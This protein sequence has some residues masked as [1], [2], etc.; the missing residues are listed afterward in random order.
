M[1]N[2]IPLKTIP[3]KNA[4]EQEPNIPIARKPTRKE[5]KEQ[6]AHNKQFGDYSDIKRLLDKKGATLISNEEYLPKGDKEVLSRQDLE[7]QRESRMKVRSYNRN[8]NTWYSWH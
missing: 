2:K 1:G 8:S 6:R 7:H 3:P 5:E 4:D